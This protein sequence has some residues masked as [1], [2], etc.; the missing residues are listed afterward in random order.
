MRGVARFGHCCR[1]WDWVISVMVA[2]ALLNSAVPLIEGMGIMQNLGL[3][4]IL[5]VYISVICV[6]SNLIW[7]L[8]TTGFNIS[9][10]L[11]AI[12]EGREKG[13]W[14]FRGYSLQKDRIETRPSGCLWIYTLGFYIVCIKIA[15]YASI[16][17]I[18]YFIQNCIHLLK[19]YWESD[20]K[21]RQY[22]RNMRLLRLFILFRHCFRHNLGLVCV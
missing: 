13:R 19:N 9:R 7:H 15:P 18:M 4:N 22:T 17:C 16:S 12:M 21:D 11:Y 5:D 1:W 8:R 2:C 14:L 20:L 10:I 3:P 6:L